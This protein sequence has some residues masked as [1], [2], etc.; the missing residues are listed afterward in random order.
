LLGVPQAGFCEL[1]GGRGR[2]ETTGKQIKPTS[3]SGKT[4][5]YLV[6]LGVVL[7]IALAVAVVYF[8]WTGQELKQWGYLG[9]FLISILGGATIIIPVPMLA[10]VLALGGVMKYTWLVGIMAGLGETLGA[11]TIYMTGHGAGTAIYNSK[12]GKIQA[13][14]ERAMKLMERRGSI[15]LFLLSAV[16]NPFFYPAA[17]AAGATKFGVRKYFIICFV[18]K[19]IK[20]MTV[21]YVGYWGLGSLL[22]MLG[23]PV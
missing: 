21:V 5:Y 1:I 13:A 7:T 19:T 22:R 10:V 11:L 9:A 14:Y 20:G 18:G 16:I 3:R 8:R 17:L 12:H 2:V 15:T 4:A 6:I 23:M